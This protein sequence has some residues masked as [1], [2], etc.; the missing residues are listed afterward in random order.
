MANARSSTQKPEVVTDWQSV[1]A[2][3]LAFLAM[4]VSDA[5]DKTLTERAAFL[6]NLGLTRRDAALLLGT[7]D[8]SLGVMMGRTRKRNTKSTSSGARSTSRRPRK[9]S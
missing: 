4:N 2:R 5:K 8:N 1:I 7:T 6:M 3:A 9:T